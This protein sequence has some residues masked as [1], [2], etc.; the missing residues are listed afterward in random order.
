MLF[1]TIGPTLNLL[2]CYSFHIPSDTMYLYNKQWFCSEILELLGIS[3]LDVSL[4]EME[5]IYVF[6][7]EITGF[8]I[9]CCA[10]GLHFEYNYH[11]NSSNSSEVRSLENSSGSD[12]PVNLFSSF[13]LPSLVTLRL[14]MVH[15]SECIGLIMLMIVAYGQFRIKVAKHEQQHQQQELHHSRYSSS[16]SSLSV[17][18]FSAPKKVLQV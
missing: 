3:I 15:S 8:I 11:E 12:L 7:A 9:L 10:A 13:S 16:S 5:E 1:L 17:S 2:S 6:V 18:N 4:I 14:D